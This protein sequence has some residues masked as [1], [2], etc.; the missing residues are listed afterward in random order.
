M[1]S[2]IWGVAVAVKQNFFS[3][4]ISHFQYQTLLKADGFSIRMQTSESPQ[5]H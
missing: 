2:S 4:D 5:E 1:K 3:N